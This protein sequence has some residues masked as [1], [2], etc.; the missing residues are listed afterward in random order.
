MVVAIPVRSRRRSASNLTEI[1]PGEQPLVALG[2]L[3]FENEDEAR[4]LA[5]GEPGQVRI[6]HTRGT[7][8]VANSGTELI[9]RHRDG[10]L[11]GREDKDECSG[12]NCPEGFHV[13]S[14]L[15]VCRR[16]Y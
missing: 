1:R 4:E 6:A 14:A 11:L 10:S 3:V 13:A 2:L 8:V 7:Q 15:R 5:G 16:H 9:A 12:K